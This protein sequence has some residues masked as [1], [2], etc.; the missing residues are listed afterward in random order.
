M[1]VDFS[2]YYSTRASKMQTSIIRRL[3]CLTQQPDIIS[4]AGGLPDNDSLPLT[5]LRSIVDLVIQESGHRALQYG[6]TH[7][8]VKLREF[9]VSFMK[10]RGINCTL[11]EVMITT[12]SQQALDLLCRV[13]ISPGD[14][15]LIENPG[16]I[17]MFAAVSSYEGT[18]V[19]VDLDAKGVKPQLLQAQAQKILKTGLKPK[20]IYY[21]PHFQ[22][23]TGVTVPLARRQEI[24]KIARELDLIVIEDDPYGELRFDG[25]AA[26]PCM[27]SFD[28][29]GRVI[30]V[31]SFSKIFAPGVRLGWIV[32]HPQ[33]IDKLILGK[34]SADACSDTLSQYIVYEYCRQNLLEDHIELLRQVYKDKRD[35][36][37]ACMEKEFPPEIKWNKPG[38]GF[39]IWVT[40]PASWDAEELFHEA[41]KE[42]VAYVIGSA[43]HVDGGGK[44]T[45][46]MNFSLPSDGQIREGI[47]RL[48]K[49]FKK[50]SATG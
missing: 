34:Q 37:L 1:S 21:I 42:K 49:V 19:G 38:G 18:M 12:G 39:F 29:E 11:E 5:D 50:K 4:F 8:F 17:G 40:L 28:P 36:M 35:V 33:I 13:L 20:F 30:F 2:Q 7:G 22:N 44:N 15:I 16:Y 48:G 41:V 24:L 23:P 43:F 26:I 45:I 14:Q 25:A 3:L 31:G 46:R 9:V 10:S 27:K 32:A 6:E 47:K